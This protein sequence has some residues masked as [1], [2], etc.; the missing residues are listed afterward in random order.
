[1]SLVPFT[2]IIYS[3]EHKNIRGFVTHGGLFGILEALTFSVPLIGIPIFADQPL[4][5]KNCIDR[6][7]A[8]SLN[9]K[10]LT[11]D[12]FASAVN[13]IIYDSKYK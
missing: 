1:M 8:V 9:Y 11:A 3:A 4:N 10:E 5:T 6:E 7:I 13:A 2:G 12:K